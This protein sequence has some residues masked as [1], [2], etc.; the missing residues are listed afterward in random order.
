MFPW[1]IEKEKRKNLSFS[2]DMNNAHKFGAVTIPE[3]DFDVLDS[4]SFL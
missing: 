2:P 3:A 4:L 1:K